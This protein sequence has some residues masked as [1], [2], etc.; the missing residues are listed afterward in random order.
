MLDSVEIIQKIADCADIYQSSFNTFPTVILIEN[1]AYAT[2]L[3]DEYIEESPDLL[4]PAKADFL[5]VSFV[6]Y[7]HNE[8]TSEERKHLG[9]IE[10]ITL[11]TSGLVRRIKDPL[12][13]RL[14]PSLEPC[15]A[16]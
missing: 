12:T 13:F 7:K 2:L 16:C 14:E 15:G 3:R 1:S 6:I 5:G 8:L 9:G 4:V 10:T 11:A